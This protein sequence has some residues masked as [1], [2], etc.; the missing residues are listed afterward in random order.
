MIPKVLSSS[1]LPSLGH[2]DGFFKRKLLKLLKFY[3]R[4]S[5]N[6]VVS[7]GKMDGLK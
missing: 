7:H 2:D 3:S 4:I 6:N 1:F 5:I